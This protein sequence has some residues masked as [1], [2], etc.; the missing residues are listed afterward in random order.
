MSLLYSFY[1]FP[2]K[3]MEYFDH[4]GVNLNFEENIKS[5]ATDDVKRYYYNLKKSPITD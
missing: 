4:F 1:E 2:L 5:F 3:V